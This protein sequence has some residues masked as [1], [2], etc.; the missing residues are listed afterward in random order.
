[1]DDKHESVVITDARNFIVNPNPNSMLDEDP[2]A[3]PQNLFFV[4]PLDKDDVRGHKRMVAKAKL[5]T[6]HIRKLISYEVAKVVAHERVM[7]FQTLSRQPMLKPAVGTLF[8][9]FVLC[10][11]ACGF[12]SLHCTRA[13]NSQGSDV[14]K[15]PSCPGE[16]RTF[17]F[18]SMTQLK[19]MTVTQLPSCFLPMSQAFPT[20]DAIILTAEHLI[21]IQVTISNKHSANKTG[22]DRIRESGIR[23]KNLATGTKDRG[24]CHVFV[25][26]TESNATALRHQTLSDVPNDIPIYSATFDVSRSDRSVENIEAFEVSGSFGY[27]QLVALI[28]DDQKLA[29]EESH[30]DIM[31][32]DD[33]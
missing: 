25:S 17:F 16:D 23:K 24:W 22:F 31:D 15:I 13:H 6:P 33:E 21:T 3:V 2:M 12:G 14:I 27:M 30:K 29:P 11:L 5:A 32:V 1:L 4:E 19:N 28:E 20:I 8:E 26:D 9:R 10:W 7:L 18:H